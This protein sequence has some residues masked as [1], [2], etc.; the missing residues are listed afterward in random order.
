MTGK[1][2][3]ILFANL[4]AQIF[5][6]VDGSFT[7]MEDTVHGKVS[8]DYPQMVAVY[9]RGEIDDEAMWP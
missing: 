9:K 3:N 4:N 6:G 2:D 5:T 1:S 7:L 8:V